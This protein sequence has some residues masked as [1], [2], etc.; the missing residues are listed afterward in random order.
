MSDP[1]LPIG[2]P[3]LVRR[4]VASDADALA[5]VAAVTFPL[6]C[7][8]H[9]TEEAKADFIRSVL[10]PERFRGYLADPDRVLFLAEDASGAL[11]YTM[12]VRGEPS[13]TDAASAITRWPTI[14]LSKCYALPG[15]HGSGV[16]A[17]L[18]AASLDEARAS[19]AAGVWLGVNQ[20][21][22][23]AR[24]FYAKHGFAVIG[25]KRFLVGDRY[26]DDFVLERV[27]E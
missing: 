16:A 24:R 8:P 26:E 22:E 20:E 19:G 9:T 11:G 15:H 4:A 7:P 18:M 13:D 25:R 17:R 14:E 27:L 5:A 3:V 1:S 12:L 2:A 6:A 10:S 21:N 23:R